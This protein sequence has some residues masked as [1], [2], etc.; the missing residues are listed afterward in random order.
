MNKI[1][2]ETQILK[3]TL[4]LLSMYYFIYSVLE[5]PYIY[6]MYS[7]QQF[8]LCLYDELNLRNYQILFFQLLKIL[9]APLILVSSFRKIAIFNILAINIIFMFANKFLHSPEQAYLNF[10]LLIL[11]CMKLP[12]TLDTPSSCYTTKFKTVY[13]LIFY[14]A[15]SYSG[16][17]KFQSDVWM[18]GFFMDNFLSYNHLV[19]NNFFTENLSVKFK[20]GLS[21]F[22]IFIEMFSFLSIFNRVLGLFFWINLT[23]IQFGLILTV[24]LWQVSFGMLI[25]H[26]F[27]ADELIVRYLSKRTIKV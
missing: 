16:L 5:F 6:D 4:I 25:C 17:T 20:V 1:E 18:K 11:L 13:F 21:Y 7:C 24:D 22:I 23:L 2:I 26:I 8:N 27:V 10:L 14:L 9:S 19:Y 12:S 3:L 15:Y